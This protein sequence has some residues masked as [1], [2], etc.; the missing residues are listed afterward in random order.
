MQSLVGGG[1][2]AGKEK[3]DKEI[4]TW[5]REATKQIRKRERNEEGKEE[6]NHKGRKWFAGFFEEDV[7]RGKKNGE[8]SIYEGG[9]E[10]P[11]FREAVTG[12]WISTLTI[13]N[14]SQF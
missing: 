11:L 10:T 4:N 3:A 5:R 14:Q 8:E 9:K 1:L 7:R 6:I 13:S 12:Q 2:S